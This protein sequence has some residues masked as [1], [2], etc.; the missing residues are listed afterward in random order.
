MELMISYELNTFKTVTDAIIFAIQHLNFEPIAISSPKSFR[1]GYQSFEKNM[2]LKKFQS[3]NDSDFIIADDFYSYHDEINSVLYREDHLHFLQFFIFK[4]EVLDDKWLNKLIEDADK[5]GFF[6]AYLTDRKKALWQ[7]EIFIH[8]YVQANKS[9]TNFTT[10]WDPILSPIV[11]QEI[12]DISKNPG[13]DKMTFGT[14]IMAAPEIWF[15]KKSLK[16]F[17]KEKIKSF[18]NA[19]K[20]EEISP[21]LLHVKL[22]NVDAL[23]FENPEILKLQSSFRTWTEM[24][25]IENELDDLCKYKNKDQFKGSIIETIAV[26]PTNLSNSNIKDN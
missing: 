7:N 6:L 13:H 1:G 21:D 14:W 11:K 18:D 24:D 15:G 20:I 5:L 22:F 10:Y 19:I 16:Y 26:M 2:I 12:I 8:H 3:N 9:H 25:R 4:F 23:D 17:E